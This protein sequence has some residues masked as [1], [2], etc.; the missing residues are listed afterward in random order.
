MAY[1]P[2][3]ARLGLWCGDMREEILSQVIISSKMLSLG[4]FAQEKM[5][6]VN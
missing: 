4:V 6:I 2:H 5:I 1:G 3:A